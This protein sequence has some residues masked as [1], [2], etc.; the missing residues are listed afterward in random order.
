MEKDFGGTYY[1]R[2]NGPGV[3]EEDA[4]GNAVRESLSQVDNTDNRTML[5][6]AV[7]QAAALA[8]PQRPGSLP[9]KGSYCDFRTE[10]MWRWEK[11]WPRKLSMS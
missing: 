6:E 10:K 2:G 4:D 9:E 7:S 3:L 11:P 1:F 8:D 5:F